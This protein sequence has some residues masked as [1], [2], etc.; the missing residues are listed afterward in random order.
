MSIISRRQKDA[1]LNDVAR[2]INNNNHTA[3]ANHAKTAESVGNSDLKLF[4]DAPKKEFV[5]RYGKKEMR[6]N[7]SEQSIKE[8]NEIVFNDNTKI[9]GIS[10]T[11]SS[12]ASVAF[13]AKGAQQL[14][15]SIDN[16]ASKEHN[17][18]DKYAAIEHNHD[19][20]YADKNHTHDSYQPKGNYSEANHNHD[21]KYADKNHGHDNYQPKGNYSEANHNHDSKYA[22]KNHSHYGI[23]SK[24]DLKEFINDITK[25]PWYIKLFKGIEIASDVLQTGFILGLDAQIKAIYAALATNGIVDTAQSMS[26]L[27]TVL[28]GYANKFKSVADTITKVGK[29]FENVNDVCQT[30]TKP[31]QYT[32]DLLEKG[33]GVVEQFSDIKSAYEFKELVG[34]IQNGGN[35]GKKLGKA[36]DYVFD[37]NLID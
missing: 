2:M 11:P 18:D 25:D 12:S 34:R 5:I 8:L 22:D 1:L 31:I 37:R 27:G 9:K 17:H 14:K 3:F 28:F 7:C 36:T 4:V 6:F 13:S 24:D 20:K 23:D 15:Q 19:D 32:A 26:T 33:A 16:I 21:T 35:V 30:V 29:I 10:D